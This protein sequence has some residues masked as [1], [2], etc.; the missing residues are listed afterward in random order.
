MNTKK[1]DK[2]SLHPLYNTYYLM[3]YRCLNKK[4]VNYKNYGGRGIEVCPRWQGKNGFKNFVT[5]I[6][7]RPSKKHTLDRID[8]NKGY[9]KINC[10]WVDSSAQNL[11]KRPKKTLTGYRGVFLD[12]R[13]TKAPYR[14]QLWA[15]NRYF[16]LGFYEKSI[17]AY[18]NYLYQYYELHGNL[19]YLDIS[20]FKNTDIN[21]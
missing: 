5:D 8:N 12:K 21:F 1:S 18:W 4:A 6:G 15:G 16:H 7:D 9:S 13:V 11:N 10:R 14:A 3:L 17:D 20:M 19:G 2:K